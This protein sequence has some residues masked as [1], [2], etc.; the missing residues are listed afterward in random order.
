[1]HHNRLNCKL[2]PWC[3]CQITIS[4][5]IKTIRFYWKG[6]FC[7]LFLSWKAS[8]RGVGRPGHHQTGSAASSIGPISIHKVVS[9]LFSFDSI[10][11][12]NLLKI[13]SLVCS[14]IILLLQHCI[15]PLQYRISQVL[16]H[17]F[18][19][20]RKNEQRWLWTI[21]SGTWKK[22]HQHLLSTRPRF[23]FV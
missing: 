2:I 20:N 5:N 22:D 18:G 19:C 1:M 8:P 21:S 4:V 16:V 23:S 13:I 11:V 10:F 12:C 9:I 15:Y 6:L 17:T 3:N 7:I 14:I